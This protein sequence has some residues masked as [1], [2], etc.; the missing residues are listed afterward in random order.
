MIAITPKSPIRFHPWP[1]VIVLLYNRELVKLIY[2]NHG[3]Q[4]VYQLKC[5]SALVIKESGRR[6]GKLCHGVCCASP[7]L[8]LKFYVCKL[9][10][11]QTAK[12]MWPP[13]CYLAFGSHW[14]C[15]WLSIDF[16]CFRWKTKCVRS[17]LSWNNFWTSVNMLIIIST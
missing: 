1:C 2:L 15:E 10:F 11:F 13:S 12:S 9:L 14:Y 3:L 5:V 4:Y 17:N 6:G 8:M 7:F 16:L